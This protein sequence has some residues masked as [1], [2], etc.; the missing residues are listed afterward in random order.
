MTKPKQHQRRATILLMVVGLL[1]MLFIIVSAF[2]TLARFDRLTLVQTEKRDQIDRVVESVT[3]TVLGGLTD[4]LSDGNGRILYPG[5]GN[6]DYMPATIPGYH[7]ARII[8]AP[9]IVRNTTLP[10]GVPLSMAAATDFRFPGI[11]QMNP[12]LDNTVTAESIGSFS[13]RNPLPRT[14]E[15]I[16]YTFDT[17]IPQETPGILV[18]RN[19]VTGPNPT[20]L[21]RGLDLIDL[22]DYAYSPFMDADGDGV[23]DTYLP[24]MASVIEQANAQVGT[25][26]RVP[27]S[28][29]FVT[30]GYDHASQVNNPYRLFDTDLNNAIARNVNIQ[31]FREYDRDAQLDVAVKVIAHGGMVFPDP[32]TIFGQMMYNWIRFRGRNP[33]PA[34]NPTTTGLR[35]LW[36]NAIASSES[37]EAN[38]RRRAGMP[39]YV[40]ETANEQND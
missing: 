19:G 22:V 40:P 20:T 27:N 26:V 35:D 34:M 17:N 4:Q 28:L 32:D 5:P 14:L 7:G 37:V 36:R 30:A 6:P 3:K 23:P 10:L 25:A 11:S 12:V 33:D 13:Y 9:T 21:T 18:D 24:A 29:E 38:L 15:F 2:I 31:Q 1:A 16:R 8:A 39:S